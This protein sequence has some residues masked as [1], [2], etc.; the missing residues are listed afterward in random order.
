MV[1]F[2]RRE[3]L[4]ILVGACHWLLLEPENDEPRRA[5]A[6]LTA[7][8]LEATE[9]DP[10]LIAALINEAN[11]HGDELSFRLDSPGYPALYIAATTARLCQTLEELQLHLTGATPRIPS[12][13][14]C[15]ETTI[16]RAGRNRGRSRPD[17]PH[18]RALQLRRPGEGELIAPSPDEKVRATSPKHE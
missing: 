12:L 3:Q 17:R 4:Q 15:L 11:A 5:L 6:L 2:E 7:G 9:L 13:T 10:P 16:I 1:S 18:R 14:P 8:G